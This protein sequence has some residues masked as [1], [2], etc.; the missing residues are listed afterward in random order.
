MTSKFSLS[1]SFTLAALISIS[2]I[3][4]KKDG[5]GGTNTE[6]LFESNVLNRNFVVAYANDK[7]SDLT[8]NYNGYT[9]ILLKTDYYQ[10]PLQVTK[11]SVVV[12]GSWSS[13]D[14]YSKLII[15]LPNTPSE[16]SFLSRAWRF[17]SKGNPLLK[18]APWGSSEAIVLHMLRL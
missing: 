11:N 12:T 5:S 4:C 6:R 10:G 17:T 14:D 2:F 13:N 18:L 9:F 1:K 15:T 7:G 3:T 8:A 16:F